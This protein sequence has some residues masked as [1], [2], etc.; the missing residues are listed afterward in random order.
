MDSLPERVHRC[1]FVDWVPDAITA[2][3]FNE[4]GT[5]LAVARENSD[6]ELWSTAHWHMEQT[7]SPSS[8]AKI[9][10]LAWSKAQR[11]LD[12]TVMAPARL[13]A[14]GLGG[15]IFEVDFAH[16]RATNARDSY[17][18]AVWALAVRPD[19]NA[20]AVGCEDGSI[21]MFTLEND[22]LDFTRSFPSGSA[23]V[24]SLA[25]HG[26]GRRLFSGSADGT[27]RQW[28][29]KTG[30]ALAR[31]VLES[32][33]GEPSLV[34]A[35]AVL[36]DMTVVSGNS[37]G[38]VQFWEGR[39][40]TLLQTF[41]RHTADVR[42]LAAAPDGRSVCASGVD[43]VVTLLQRARSASGAA[44]AAGGGGGGGDDGSAWVMVHGTRAHTHDVHTLAIARP[45][46][47]AHD[48]LVTGG[49]DTQLCV[50]PLDPA[51]FKADRLAVKLPPFPQRSQLAAALAPR[52][53]LLMAPRSTSVLE[54]WQLA[55]AEASSSSPSAAA[56]APIKAGERVAPAADKQLGARLR[57][58][59]KALCAAL[60]PNGQWLAASDSSELK[61]WRLD[62]VDGAPK[63]R[64][65]P[66]RDTAAGEALGEAALCACFSPSSAALVLAD[67][68]GRV[69]VFDVEKQ[70][71]TATFEHRGGEGDESGEGS[72]A[73]FFRGSLAPVCTLAV[74]PDGQWLAV[75]DLGNNVH[76]YN[77]DTA[78]Y[79]FT[80]PQLD[81]M[82]TALAFD[83]ASDILVVACASNRFHI[84][85]IEERC[86]AWWSQQYGERIPQALT[87]RREKIVSIVF[88]PSERRTLYL[89]SHGWV[90]RVDLDEVS[91]G[92]ATAACE[93]CRRPHSLPSTLR[94][95]SSPPVSSTLL[96]SCHKRAGELAA[97][98]AQNAPTAA[99][100]LPTHIPAPA[101]DP[102]SLARPLRP[103]QKLPDP[104][105]AAPKVHKK[106]GQKRKRGA[107][108]AAVTDEEDD[109]NFKISNEFKPLFFMGFLAPQERVVVETPWLK[110]MQNFPD[111]LFRA[112]YGT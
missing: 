4:D 37:R 79:H 78:M 38:Q 15:I 107:P 54:L 91:A 98:R 19:G 77:L 51:L 5:Y 60:A 35:L 56:G 102:S 93:R 43:N 1:R 74:S 75:G 40:G 62:M 67:R 25:W 26:G 96:R 52:A 23:R 41:D 49:V 86:L 108:V 14:A 28:E 83:P 110:I 53:R 89:C 8:S 80:L 12:G 103:P 63:P 85:D 72:R 22:S 109:K 65:V 34:W 88:D 87:K 20:L 42:A 101:A 36:D 111:M 55:P 59:S 31:I 90:C 44:A 112:K 33:G 106:G 99:S 16:A 104:D 3:A 10:C 57:L 2:V 69:R 48:V 71:L 39:F 45:P 61:L 24:L 81:S 100:F 13:F 6:I 29:G 66:P 58:Q 76:V 18:G 32:F 7:I 73:A 84:F 17:G 105:K 94:P 68:F 50:H 9:R 64:R 11:N 95:R 82:H 21:R 70:A 46:G 92:A 47:S 97:A 30:Q 27:I